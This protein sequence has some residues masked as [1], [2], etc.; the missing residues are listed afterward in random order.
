MKKILIGF[1]LFIGGCGVI[2]YIGYVIGE[3]D[4]KKFAQEWPHIRAKIDSLI[5]MEKYEDALKLI[6]KTKDDFV[7][8]FED[9][10][11]IVIY[12]KDLERFSSFNKDSLIRI[13]GSMP[14]STFKKFQKTGSLPS[15][16]F[17]ISTLNNKLVQKLKDLSLDYTAW[18]IQ[19]LNDSCRKSL[20]P[21]RYD[22]LAQIE[23]DIKRQMYN[24]ESYKRLEDKWFFTYNRKKKACEGNLVFRILGTNAF[25][26]KVQNIVKVNMIFKGDR[27]QYWI[28]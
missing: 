25:G 24:P 2:A 20:Y 17:H 12:E 18:R 1:L 16:I 27:W 11:E 15:P 6:K 21:R 3:H 4:K 7:I 22:M 28:R 26:G 8:D 14:E 19:Y 10:S 23:E 9:T 13:L 5:K